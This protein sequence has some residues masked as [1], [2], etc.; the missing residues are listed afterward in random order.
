MS[1]DETPNPGEDSQETVYIPGNPGAN[2]TPEEVD[3]IRERIL[4]AITPIWPEKEILGTAGKNWGT[5][6]P[7]GDTTENTL[8]RLAFHDCIPYLDGGIN[9]RL[10]S[11]QT[12]SKA[13]LPIFSLYPSGVQ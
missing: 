7:L 5:N 11:F 6:P 9:D 3:S 8:M 2:W 13:T 1:F 4:Q 10:V 12:V